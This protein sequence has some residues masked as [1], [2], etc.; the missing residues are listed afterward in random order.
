MVLAEASKC[1]FLKSIIRPALWVGM[2]QPRRALE[3]GVHL[4]TGPNR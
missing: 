3:S 4:A 2:N 1:V